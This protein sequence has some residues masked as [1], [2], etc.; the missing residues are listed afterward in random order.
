MLLLPRSAAWFCSGEHQ[1]AADTALL[2]LS[3]H[4][5]GALLQPLL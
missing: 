3:T 5:G 1:F 2:P 4:I